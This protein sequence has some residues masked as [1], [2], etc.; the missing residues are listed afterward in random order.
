MCFSAPASLTSAA[1]LVTASALA[2]RQKPAPQEWPYAL[3]PLLFGI[4]QLLEGL[5]WLKLQNAAALPVCLSTDRLAQGFSLFSQVFWPLFVPVAVGLMET[6]RWRRRAI[7][8]CTLA[9]LVVS[10]FLLS[11]MLQ[12][13]IT[14]QLQGQHI[15]YAFSHTHVLM[16]STLYLSGACLSPLLS[17]HPSVRVFG[18]AAVATA[19]LSYLVFATWFISVWCFFA[20]LMSCVVLLHFYPAAQLYFKTHLRV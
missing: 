17:S 4:Q 13:P 16:A 10:M 2:L 11:A 18:A 6:V 5:L 8:A 9:G 7:A 20:G 12:V 1:L 14:A 3:M 15:A 19:G